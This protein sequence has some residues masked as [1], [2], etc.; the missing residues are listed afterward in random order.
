M[1]E[2]YRL[3]KDI[4][5]SILL[6]VLFGVGLYY[7]YGYIQSYPEL[8]ASAFITWM[9][10]LLLVIYLLLAL[11]TLRQTLSTYD[12]ERFDPGSRDSMKRL[13]KRLRYRLPRG[14][15]PL[16]QIMGTFET[17]LISRG[18]EIEYEDSIAGRV[19]VRSRASGLVRRPL[20]DRIMIK[21]HDA[22][23]VILV[24]QML[25]DCIRFIRSLRQRR[26]ERNMLVIITETADPF[27]TA[28]AAAGVVNFLGKFQGGTLGPVLLSGRHNRLF[29]PAD[30]T[31]LPRNHRRMQNNVR[32][33]L[34]SVIRRYKKQIDTKS[35]K[36]VPNS[37]QIS[38]PDAKE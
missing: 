33:M 9:F 15:M 22:L 30:R 31:I 8:I 25:Q 28:S 10:R 3:K 7:L 26:S 16:E 13:L 18:Y 32:R 11:V 24:D 38:S 19:Y 37:R 21:R 34:A 6:V 17:K 36:P 23:N 14:P 1:F 29:Y 4:F 27:D 12:L 5:I 20:A 35:T 2:R